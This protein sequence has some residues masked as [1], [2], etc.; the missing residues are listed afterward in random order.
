MQKVKMPKNKNKP[1]PFSLRLTQEERRDLERR[2]AGLSLAAYIKS[3][4]FG[5]QTDKRRTRG[6]FPAEDQKALARAL[7]LLGKSQIA[8]SL[9]ELAYAARVGTLALTPETE[10]ALHAACHHV[11]EI[12]T[13]LMKALGIR[14]R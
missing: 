8:D 2:A 4:L 10:A 5:E 13:L 6:K 9:K 3:C 7:G 14:E 11:Q 1:M 12:K